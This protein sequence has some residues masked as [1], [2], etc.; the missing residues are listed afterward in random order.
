LETYGV[1]TVTF[2]KGTDNIS[3]YMP[4]FASSNFQ[5]SLVILGIFLILVGV[6]CYIAHKLTHKQAIAHILTQHGNRFMP[7]IFI[8]L[9]AFMVFD[10]NSLSLIPFK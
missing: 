1:A 5:S 8:G 9:G 6:L 10:S 2:T 3:I 7:S 4:I